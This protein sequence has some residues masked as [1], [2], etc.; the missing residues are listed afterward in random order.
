MNWFNPVVILY[1]LCVSKL[2]E[3]HQL[4]NH[5]LQ[6]TLYRSE[7]LRF[8]Y[9]CPY[10]TV[11]HNTIFTASTYITEH[12]KAGGREIPSPKQSSQATFTCDDGC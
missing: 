9:E 2:R 5:K 6:N 8:G 12:T 4:S 11:E 3:Y 7:D 10:E 1:Q